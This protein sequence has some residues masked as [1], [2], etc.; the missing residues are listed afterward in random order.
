MSF[1]GRLKGGRAAAIKLK[2]IALISPHNDGIINVSLMCETPLELLHRVLLWVQTYP[3]R[4]DWYYIQKCLDTKAFI[5]STVDDH[6]FNQFGFGRMRGLTP[7]EEKSMLPNSFLP[8][9]KNWKGFRL[10]RETSKLQRPDLSL[11]CSM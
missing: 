7:W 9:R 2:Q 11:L 1:H 8:R 10:R 5:E 6:E 3:M 4:P